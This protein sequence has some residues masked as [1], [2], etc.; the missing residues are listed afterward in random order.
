MYARD[1]LMYKEIVSLSNFA[2]AKM[3]GAFDVRRARRV[4]LH[5]LRRD[6]QF[7]LNFAWPTLKYDNI[8][9]A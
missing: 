7:L 9:I 4:L 3:L 8:C 6:A 1:K 2:H 5:S